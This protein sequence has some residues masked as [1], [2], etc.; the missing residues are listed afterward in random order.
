[1]GVTGECLNMNIAIVE[2]EAAHGS[3][4][5]QY[6]S[7]WA[8]AENK[9]VH[10]FIYENAQSFLFNLEDMDF[11]AVF[12]DIQM[13]GMSGME[14]IWKL[15]ESDGEIPVVITSGLTEYLEEGYEVK[16]LHYLIKPISEEKV[17]ECMGRVCSHRINREMFVMRTQDG[18][19][20]ADLKE[21]NYC[22][23]D[24]HYTK[25]LMTDKSITR[26]IKSISEMERELPCETFARCH[27]SYLCN[28]ENVKQITQDRVIFDNGESVPVSRRMYRDFNRRF[29]QFYCTF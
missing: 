4:L 17:F 9:S 25:L 28:L 14:M 29:I 12:A 8:K 27:R 15:R 22:E 10:V 18:V 1:M 16:A 11:D 26:V 13:P 6:I 21:I 23:A 24:G 7:K 2:D 5:K 20:R 3:L 19:V